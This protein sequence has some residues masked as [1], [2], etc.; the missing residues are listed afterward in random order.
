MEWLRAEDG[1]GGVCPPDVSFA[2]GCREGRRCN[3]AT[4]P[5]LKM[6]SPPSDTPNGTQESNPSS[7]F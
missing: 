4:P 3:T 1:G 2:T 6:R 7:D 5:S